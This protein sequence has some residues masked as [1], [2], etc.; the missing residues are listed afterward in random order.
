[1]HIMKWPLKWLREKL[2]DIF[3][4]NPL[5]SIDVVIM[6]VPCCSGLKNAVLAALNSINKTIPVNIHIISTK[7]DLLS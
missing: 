6:E 5:K 4:L 3:T 2:Q 7:G 1:M